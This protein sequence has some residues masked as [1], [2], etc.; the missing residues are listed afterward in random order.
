MYLSG[1]ISP[2]FVKTLTIEKLVAKW[3][4][5]TSRMSGAGLVMAFQIGNIK[6]YT[7]VQF[8]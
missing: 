3:L 4:E 2:N 6:S 1:D 7:F 8:L 5:N